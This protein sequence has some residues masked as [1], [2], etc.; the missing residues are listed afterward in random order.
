MLT[1]V[2]QNP[3]AIGYASLA[4]VKDSVKALSV[5]GVVPSEDTVKDGSY[6]VQRPFV[7][8]T[9]EGKELSPAAQAFFDY[10]VSSDAASIIAKAGAVAVA[11]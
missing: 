1:A 4:A 5:D 7:L 2:S 3:N 6:K 11:G 10:A 8:V 9:M